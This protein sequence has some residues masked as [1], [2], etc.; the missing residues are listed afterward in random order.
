MI[1]ALLVLAIIGFMGIYMG[2]YSITDTDE[3][4]F[5]EEDSG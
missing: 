5:E 1:N 3:N 2:K 4:K